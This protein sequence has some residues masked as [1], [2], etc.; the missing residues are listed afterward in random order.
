MNSCSNAQ[1]SLG[2]APAEAGLEFEFTCADN[3]QNQDSID[4][5]TVSADNAPCGSFSYL[6]ET[7]EG[8][9]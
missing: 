5:F 8:S 7:G 6:Y 3:I 4:E 9:R 1:E 2:L